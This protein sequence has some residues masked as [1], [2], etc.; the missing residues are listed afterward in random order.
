MGR[1]AFLARIGLKHDVA[2]DAQRVARAVMTQLARRMSAAELEDAK[3]AG[4]AGHSWTLARVKAPRLREMLLKPFSGMLDHRFHGSRL[5]K[6]MSCA[7]DDLYLF[8]RPQQGKRLFVELDH[9]DVGAPDNKQGGRTDHGDC[10]TSKIRPTSAR[11]YGADPIGKPG[12]SNQRGRSAVA[13]TE[14]AARKVRNRRPLLIKPLHNLDET[15]RKQGNIEDIGPVG[16]FC[17][18]QQVEQQGSETPVVQG[19]GDRHIA[20]AN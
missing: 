1:D 18:R 16:L 9:P 3:A 11:D 14:Q 13:G 6:E 20:R 7:S 4:A 2:V 5:R 10:I 17:W 12:R 19:L 8:R 15:I